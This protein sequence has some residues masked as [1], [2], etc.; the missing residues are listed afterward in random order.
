MYTQN[1]KGCHLPLCLFFGQSTTFLCPFMGLPHEVQWALLVDLVVFQQFQ[2]L[3]NNYI[4]LVEE[5]QVEQAV[6]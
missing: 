2:K 6:S 1:I 4:T 3:Q 5:A